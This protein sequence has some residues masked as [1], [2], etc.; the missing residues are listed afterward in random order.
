MF[1]K[2]FGHS[3]GGT[4]WSDLSRRRLAGG[5]D[6]CLDRLGQQH[7]HVREASSEE[8]AVNVR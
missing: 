3:C 2:T 1:G 4:V 8:L 5:R 6:V 7:D